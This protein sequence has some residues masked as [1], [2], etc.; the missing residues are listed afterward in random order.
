MKKR[1]LA[2]CIVSLAAYSSFAQNVGIGTLTPDASAALDISNTGKGLLIPRMST[3]AI[4]SI[5]NPAKGLFVY[6]SVTNQLMVNTGTP[7]VPS[8]K[9]VASNGAWSLGGNAGINPSTQFVG[10]TDNQ[11]LRFRVNNIPAGE[12]N[13]LSGNVFWGLRAG[14]SNTAGFSNIAIGTDALKSNTVRGN[15]VAVGD[16]ALFN[17]YGSAT[18][19][20][21]GAANTAIGSKALFSNTT[22]NHNTAIGFRS[23]TSNTA[24]YS[25]TA[26]G[27]QALFANTSGIFNSALGQQALYS[28]TSGSLNVGVG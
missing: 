7:A 2:V 20:S 9:A 11:P 6:D 26:A 1:F 28:N 14:Q 10:N 13:P 22:G 5:T 23:L 3:A 21:E 4:N 8:W 27:V 24:G 19:T 16:S 25:N 17:N 18:E 15:L 12:L